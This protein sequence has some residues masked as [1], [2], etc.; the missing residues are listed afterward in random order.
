LTVKAILVLAD[1]RLIEAMSFA[2]ARGQRC[3]LSRPGK[4]FRSFI[5]P[6]SQ[7]L[8]NKRLV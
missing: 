7:P 4:R 3:F 2:S 6:I 1:E 5:Q 8:Y